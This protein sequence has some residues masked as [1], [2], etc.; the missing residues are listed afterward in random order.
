M[1]IRSVVAC[2][3]RRISFYGFKLGRIQNV[4]LFSPMVSMRYNFS[5][6]GTKMSEEELKKIKEQGREFYDNQ[7]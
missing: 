4:G 1:M 7:V 6:K 2:T 3:W 5:T